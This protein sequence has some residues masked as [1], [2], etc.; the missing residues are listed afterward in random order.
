VNRV[1]FSF[2]VSKILHSED[3]FDFPW[4]YCHIHIRNVHVNDR[5]IE[6][7]NCGGMFRFNQSSKTLEQGLGIMDEADE[8]EEVVSEFLATSFASIV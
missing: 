6:T 2:G 4:H 5:V 8:I 7:T 3:T 1:L